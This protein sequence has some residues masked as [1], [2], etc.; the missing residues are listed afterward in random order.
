MNQ[1]RLG[2]YFT[3]AKIL[4]DKIVEFVKNDSS[5]ILEPSFG[6]G[7]LV[8]L[9]PGRQFECYEIDK[10]LKPPLFEVDK[11][12]RVIYQDFLGANIRKKYSTIIGNPP[13]VKTSTGNLYL[14][15]IDKCHNLLEMGGELI[16][17]APSDFVKLTS[18]KNLV[19]KMVN[20]GHFTDIYFSN[21]ETLFQGASID[22]MI[23][24]YVLG[25][26]GMST[27]INGV[28]KYMIV[29]DGIITFASNELDKITIE[30]YFNIYVGMVS[31]KEE[32]FKND[33][34]GN[35]DIL[36][37]ENKRS[38]Y[39]FIE[40]FP[41]K[42]KELDTYL[43]QNKEILL[44]RKIRA[45]NYKNWFEWGAPRNKSAMEQHKGKECIYVRN[46]TRKKII[47]FRGIVEYFGASLLCMIPKKEIDLNNIIEKINSE[48]IRQN[49][50]YSGRFR[51]GQ[52]QLSKLTMKLPSSYG[53]ASEVSI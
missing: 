22:T 20:T 4:Q 35:I 42:S 29:N 46:I 31:G 41:T 32:V 45:F 39:I 15:F 3:T 12:K 50:T 5:I 37:D 34:F 49:Y 18:A 11:T 47:A 19:K 17:I 7:H 26:K 53:L 16:F 13:Y 43:T 10:T 14:D 8:Q 28:Q 9:F 27:A 48:E 52:R 33:E 38:K 25:E 2:Q 1:K 44:A 36:I 23:F 6:K 51:I 30:E 21:D 40:K 24:R